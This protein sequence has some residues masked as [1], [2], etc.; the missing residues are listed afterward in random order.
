MAWYR[1]QIGGEQ[2]HPVV[3]AAVV[4][5]EFVAIHPFD[6]GN[7]RMARILVNLILMQYSFPPVVIQLGEHE[8]YFFALAKADAGETEEF[9]CF[10]AEKLIASLQLYLRGARG[11][12]IDEMD[13]IDKKVALFKQQFQHLPDAIP[14]SPEIS[15]AFVVG[16]IRIILR[17][18]LKKLSMY[19]DLFFSNGLN[20]SFGQRSAAGPKSE[21][22][23]LE[24]ENKLL[25]S[26]IRICAFT[27]SWKGF[28]KEP[29]K[30]FSTSIQINFKFEDFQFLVGGGVK[31]FTRLYSEPLTE[32]D[33]E[34]LVKEMAEA[35]YQSIENQ[36]RPKK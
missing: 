8:K 18:A 24:L 14:Y 10:I 34:R 22:V 27:F 36:S 15:K 11:E 16:P 21:E 30:G 33:C 12:S 6:D 17:K 31:S 29:M 26:P 35:V 28:R 1:K 20:Y 5:H 3:T 23:L 2:I 32:E 9:V 25:R 13:D 7:G 4:H 19:D